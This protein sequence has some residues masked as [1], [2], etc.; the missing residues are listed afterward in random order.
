MKKITALF[1]LLLLVLFSF[2]F[3]GKSLA[4]EFDYQRAYA[5]YTYNLGLYQKAHSEYTVAKSA[6]L[7]SETLSAREKAQSATAGMLIARDE[8]VRTYLTALRMKLRETKGVAET[9]RETLYILID[10]EVDWF[11]THKLGISSAASLEDLQEDSEEAKARYSSSELVI[12]KA[13][14]AVSVGKLNNFQSRMLDLVSSLKAK[15]AEIRAN[16][17]KDTQ[18]LERWVLEVE[19]RMS[20]SQTK[21]DEAVAIMAKVKSSERDKAKYFEQSQNILV[22]SGQYLKEASSFLKQ[23][24]I[25]IK[26]ED[27]K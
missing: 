15:I 3:P 10:V 22:E 27:G 2:F 18:P 9:D 16:G 8:V 21:E 17:D 5:D 23:I 6:Y 1:F 24:I 11:N 12:Y 26:T 7:A 14:N 20:R 13:L 19:N 25:G 4:Q